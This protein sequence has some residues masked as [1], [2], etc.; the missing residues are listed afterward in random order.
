MIILIL[1]SLQSDFPDEK[2]VG[3]RVNYQ[4]PLSTLKLGKESV[5]LST[6]YKDDFT[7]KATGKPKSYAPTL[8]YIRP[9]VKMESSTEAHDSFTGETLKV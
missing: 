2:K 3:E 6:N 1:E 9:G 5:E 8:P 7:F 4:P